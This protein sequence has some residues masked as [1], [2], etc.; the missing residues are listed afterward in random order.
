MTTFQK[1]LIRELIQNLILSIAFLNT[2]LVIEK[3]LK[4]SKIFASVGIDLLNL[5]LLIVMLQPQ[6]LIFTIPMSLLLSVLL[7]YGRVI[8]DNE[9]LTLMVSGM[10]YKR[11]FKPVLYIGLIAFILTTFMSFYIAPKGVSLVREKILSLLAER[12]PLGLEEGIFNQGF[13]GVTIFIKEKPDI[14]HLKEVI[15]FD[16]R[17]EDKIIVIAK[18]GIIKKEKE[19][20]VLSLIDGKAY[21]NRGINLNEIK[22]KEYIFKLSPN[23]EPIAKKISEYSILELF[24]KFQTDITRRTDYKI[25][26][27]KRIILPVLCIISVFL[28]PSL[29]LLIGKS[30]RLGGITIGLSV[31]TLYYIFMIYGANLAKAGKISPELG[32]FSPMFIFGLMAFVFYKKIRI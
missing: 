25:E 15:I 31:F 8:A 19:N 2:I 29:C 4:L 12:A 18:E 11:T 17:K 32:A 7:T 26:F 10:P 9:M 5:F 3:L 22:F 14:K 23:I 24:D 13:K 21:F 16:E 6:L 20:I 27:Y 1:A 30:G 28:T